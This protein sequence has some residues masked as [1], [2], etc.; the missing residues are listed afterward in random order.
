M[1]SKLVFVADDDLMGVQALEIRL[2]ST[3]LRVATA[4]NGVTALVM[5]LKLRPD[6]VIIDV[7]MPGADGMRVCE[8]L[9]EKHFDAPIIVYTGNGGEDIVRR[10]GEL[11]AHHALKGSVSWESL[12]PVIA[13]LLNASSEQA[14]APPKPAAAEP[15][16]AAPPG[17][18]KVLAVDDDRRVCQ[19]I[20]IRLGKLGIQVL[21]AGSGPEGFGIALKERPDAIITDYFMPGGGGDYFL[22]RL[23]S[24]SATK[25]TPVIILTGGRSLDGRRD[26]ALE[27]ELCSR[28]GSVG[29]LNKPLDFNL[30]LAELRR[31]MAIPEAVPAV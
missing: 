29:F 16:P 5:I 9:R 27:R 20:A 23:R 31:H 26:Y 11:D 12:R 21:T 17:A 28:S 6:L 19:A 10:C 8:R 3:G 25:Q 4:T 1:T 2:K 14:G 13:E 22:H 18:S 15:R 7:G 24:A 30:L